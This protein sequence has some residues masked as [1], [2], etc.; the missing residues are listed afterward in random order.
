MPLPLL[1]A[2]S[3]TIALRPCHVLFHEELPSSSILVVRGGAVGPTAA[4]PDGRR[5][6]I[7]LLGPGDLVPTDGLARLRADLLAL[8]RGEVTF[9]SIGEVDRLLG[10]NPAVG[11]WLAHGLTSRIDQLQ[12]GLAAALTLGV[13]DRTLAILRVLARRW[14][15]PTRTGTVID[16]AVPQDTLAAMVGATRESVN[17][18]LR[19]LDRRGVVVRSEGRYAL[20]ESASTS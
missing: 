19:G 13:E 18:A 17:R 5:A 4:G 1:D 7:D 20:V 6:V 15:R 14:G 8:S 11:A 3:T 12:S 16:L 2:C 9:V 10:R